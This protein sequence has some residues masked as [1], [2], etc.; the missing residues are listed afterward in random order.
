[1][2]AAWRE[3]FVANRFGETALALWFFAVGTFA[4]V[5]LKSRSKSGDWEK[6]FFVSLTAVLLFAQYYYPHIKAAWGGGTPVDITIFF[7]K[8]SPIRANQ[9]ISAQLIDESDEGYYILAPN[10][11]RAI[12]VPR[13][14]VSLVYFSGKL[15]DSTLLQ[16]T[17]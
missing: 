10:E 2:Q 7:K 13:A 3:L 15:A 1:V 17:K 8:D 5:E 14:D 12:Y 16:N 9:A 4:I 11:N 6:T